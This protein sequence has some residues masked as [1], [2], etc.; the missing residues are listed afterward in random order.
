LAYDDGI[1]HR[2]PRPDGHAARLWPST[3]T[4]PTLKALLQMLAL[5]VMVLLL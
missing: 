3:S 1:G 5:M 2:P 4:L